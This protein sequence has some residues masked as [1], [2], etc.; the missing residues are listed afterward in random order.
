MYITLCVD[1]H[2]RDKEARMPWQ[3]VASAVY[4]PAARD[5]ARHF[6][7]RYNFTKVYTSKLEFLASGQFV[8]NIT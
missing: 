1:T 3:D 5:V 8:H 2:P 6:I 4:G 7:Q